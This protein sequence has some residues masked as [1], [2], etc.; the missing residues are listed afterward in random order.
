M[1]TP[2]TSPGS[3]CFS[4]ASCSHLCRLV[5]SH[6]VRLLRPRLCLCCFF[7][8]KFLPIYLWLCWVSVA[9][10]RLSLVAV[11]GAQGSHCSGCSCCR[12]RALGT[13]ASAVATC[14]L[15]GC[16]APTHMASSWTRITPVSPELQGRFLTAG[17]PG[18]P[19]L[20]HFSGILEAF[21]ISLQSLPV[22]THISV[23]V[24]LRRS[25]RA[26]VSS[27]FDIYPV[28]PD[29]VPSALHAFPLVSLTAVSSRYC[30][31]RHPPKGQ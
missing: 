19:H 24:F 4:G 18:K 27:S 28:L 20:C 25:L 23:G 30:S 29:I 14:R 9:A 22:C 12:A 16:V 3:W 13:R 21:C 26:G 8:F 11:S 6:A 7:I 5:C 15:S 10:P 17:P 2:H 1:L 31:R